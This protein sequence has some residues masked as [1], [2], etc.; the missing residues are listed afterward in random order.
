M[1]KYNNITK[2]LS[3]VA[4]TGA[5]MLTAACTD[6]FDKW[7]INPNEATPDQMQQDNLNT[8]AYFAQMQRGVLRVGR[9]MGGEYQISETLDAGLF[10]GYFATINPGYGGVASNHNDMYNLQPHWYDKP[11]EN[12]YTQI[13]QPWREIVKVT[14]PTSPAR[15]MATIIKVLGMQRITDK[16]GPIPYSAFGEAIEL[17]YDSQKDVYYAMF[18]ELAEAITNLTTYCDANSNPYLAKYDIVYSG[19]ARKWVKMANTLRLRMAMRVS[20]VD[21]AKARTEAQAALANTYGLMTSKSDDAILHNNTG[22]FTYTN[23]L[24]ETQTSWYD[25]AMSATIDV[26]LNGYN[27]PRMAA[28]FKANEDGNY[29]GMRNGTANP[30]KANCHAKCS[31]VNAEAT[32]DLVWMRAAEAYFLLA[33]AKLRLGLGDESVQSYYEKGVRESFASVGAA[34]VDKY[35]ADNESRPNT[36]WVNPVNNQNVSVAD[37][38]S[39]V[40][41]AWDATASQAKQLE[42]IMTQKWLALFPD[43]MEAWSEMRRT[44]YPGF[45]RINSYNAT[46]EVAQ[47]ELISRLKFPSSEYSNNSANAQAAAATLVGGDKA[48]SR[49]WWDVKR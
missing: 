20:Y 29:R 6:S 47:N 27:D 30:N 12:A 33:E 46:T 40:P 43:G 11:F 16:Y 48:G 1:K 35:L 44:G 32:S 34:D 15:A 42:Q 28:Y 49:L 18:D 2:I 37:W 19:D 31:A 25:E 36:T 39:D 14:E 7:N 13:M 4:M 9:D 3:G 22:N 17:P 45:V 38:V 21:E 41:T 5:L 10:A 23:P 24:W 26:Y 8:G